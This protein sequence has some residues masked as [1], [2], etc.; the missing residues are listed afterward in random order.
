MTVPER[1]VTTP[2]V[3]EDG[4]YQANLVVTAEPVP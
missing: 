1:R 3:P 4:G 2:F